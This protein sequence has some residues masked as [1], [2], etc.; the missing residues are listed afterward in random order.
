M[1]TRFK[2]LIRSIFGGLIDKSEDPELILKQ[3]MRDM[4]DE[5][6]KMRENVAQVMAA[7]KRLAREIDVNQAKLIDIDKKVKAAIRTNHDDIATSMIT[8]MQTVQRTL[9]T[10]KMNYEQAKLASTKAQKFL[11]EYMAQVRKRT[12]EAMEM[13]SANRQAQMQERVAQTMSGFQ[14]GD[15]SQTFDD[16][17]E[18]IAQR[19]ASAEAKAELASSGFDSR[20]NTIEKELDQIQAQDALLEYKKQMG[21]LPEAKTPEALTDG[22]AVKSEK[23]RIN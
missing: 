23:D 18:K 6:P 12:N 22:T 21:L 4:Q 10:T 15:T 5:V 14:L 9:D 2:R 1:W 16:M 13:V 20:M 11:D 8:E 19:S 17:R 3:L 7:E